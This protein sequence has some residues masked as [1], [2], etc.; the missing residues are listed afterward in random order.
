MATA[1]SLD[2]EPGVLELVEEA[3]APLSSSEK[4]LRMAGA[5]GDISE[6]FPAHKL[7]EIGETVVSA[8][9]R[10]LVDRK[11]WEDTARKALDACSQEQQIKAKTFPW[12]NASNMRWPL[13]GSADP[14]D[15]RGRETRSQ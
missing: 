1:Y 6:I 15:G 8:Y 7:A 10:D 12:A 11:D 3:P 13:R 9:E 4:L 14:A 5:S 2:D